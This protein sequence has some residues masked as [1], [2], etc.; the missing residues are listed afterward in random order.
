[1][2][3]SDIGYFAGLS[4]QQLKVLYDIWRETGLTPTLERIQELLPITFRH[5]VAADAVA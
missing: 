5:W 4:P 1:M 3:E 2:A